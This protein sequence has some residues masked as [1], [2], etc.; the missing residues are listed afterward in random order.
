MPDVARGLRNNNPGNIDYH[1]ENNWLGQT[2]IEDP[3]SNGSQRF[4]KFNTP[5]YGIRA[6]AMLLLKY[7]YTYSL[8][9]IAGML[10]RWAPNKENAT[11]SYISFVSNKVGIDPYA[12]IDI[13]NQVLLT[14]IVTAIIF[15]ECG[16]N[17]Y[18]SNIID[19]GVQMA[20]GSYGH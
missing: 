17:P 3:A 6:I 19:A 1:T 15:E 2:G 11:T 12:N 16:S 18:P 8:H 7:Y 10:S 5:A 13:N 14:N 20:M 4:A 9:N